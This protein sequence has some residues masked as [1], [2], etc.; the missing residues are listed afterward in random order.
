[1]RDSTTY[2]FLIHSPLRRRLNDTPVRAMKRRRNLLKV[3]A[4]NFVVIAVLSRVCCDDPR[5]D[6]FKHR[7]VESRYPLIILRATPFLK[8]FRLVEVLMMPPC[9]NED[10]SKPILEAVDKASCLTARGSST[11]DTTMDD[12]RT[13]FYRGDM[14][15][16]LSRGNLPLRA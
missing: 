12:R 11:S 5:H 3:S 14:E 9:P 4:M 15:Q 10:D 6:V 8:N 7:H 16:I 2:S 13:L 1:M